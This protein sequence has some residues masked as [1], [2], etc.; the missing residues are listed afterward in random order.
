MKNSYT[1][2]KNTKKKIAKKLNR[3][4]FKNLLEKNKEQLINHAFNEAVELA[5]IS[6]YGSG[7]LGHSLVSNPDN[8]SDMEKAMSPLRSVLAYEATASFARVLE[9]ILNNAELKEWFYSR[10]ASNLGS[11]GGRKPGFKTP[12]IEWLERTLKSQIAR[13]ANSVKPMSA[14]EHFRELLHRD[15]ISGKDD[16]ENLTFTDQALADFGYPEPEPEITFSA[17]SEALTRI[18]KSSQKDN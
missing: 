2:K 8:I 7:L 16:N 5:L 11:R 12:H 6:K 9:G 3:E 13:S 17:V 1:S 14:K 15:E 10:T 4:L 18:N